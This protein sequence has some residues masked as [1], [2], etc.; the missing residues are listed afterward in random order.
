MT[1]WDTLYILKYLDASYPALHW[2]DHR[3][4]CA[5]A[6]TQRATPIKM[7]KLNIN[8]EVIIFVDDSSI[9]SHNK[10]SLDLNKEFR[11]YKYNIKIGNIVLFRGD[12]KKSLFEKLP[13]NQFNWTNERTFQGLQTNNWNLVIIL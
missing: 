2:W 12:L 13:Y 4:K 6:A 8:G 7:P 10:N 1:L 11:V 5:S 3:P 9:L